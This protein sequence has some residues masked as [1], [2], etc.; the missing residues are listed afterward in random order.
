MRSERDVTHYLLNEEGTELLY[1]VWLDWPVCE[2]ES[3]G[4]ECLETATHFVGHQDVG[5]YPACSK[6]ARYW[7]TPAIPIRPRYPVLLAVDD[8]EEWQVWCPYCARCHVHSAEEGHRLQ[9]C[10]S[11]GNPFHFESA[12]GYYIRHYS[13]VF[14]T[15]QGLVYAGEAQLEESDRSHGRPLDPSS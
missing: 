8:G 13:S 12:S 11:E 7:H 15:L 6:H 5:F 14:P 4:S 2:E 10:D 3:D 9:H 1:P